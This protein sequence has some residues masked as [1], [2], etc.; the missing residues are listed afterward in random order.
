M[1]TER[2]VSRARHVQARPKFICETIPAFDGEQ[3]KSLASDDG[4]AMGLL[5]LSVVCATECV[6]LSVGYAAM[7][8]VVL[9][10]GYVLY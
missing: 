4:S 5:V 8:C 1:S 2:S 10:T 3:S 9:S 6:V 7:E